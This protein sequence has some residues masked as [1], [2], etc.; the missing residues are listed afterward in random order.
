MLAQGRTITSLRER[1][2]AGAEWTVALEDNGQSEMYFQDLVIGPGGYTGWH[3]HPGLLLITMKEGSIDFYNKDCIKTTYTAG[4]SFSESADPHAAVNTGSINARLL[5]AYVIKSG[6]P[7]R[8]E[9]P[10]PNCGAA[11]HIP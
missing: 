7:R 2:K 8:I 5:V 11:L 6:E 3:S 10:Q 4:Q 9:R 1:I